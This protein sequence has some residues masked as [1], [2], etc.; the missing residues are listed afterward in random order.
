MDDRLGALE[1]GIVNPAAGD[2]HAAR[3]ARARMQG[4]HIVA[5]FRQCL[6][7][8]PTNQPGGSGEDD[9]RSFRHA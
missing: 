6:R 7:Q 1:E 8:G 4:P 2:I 3:P 9:A 5:T